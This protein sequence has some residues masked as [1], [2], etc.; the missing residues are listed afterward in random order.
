[1]NAAIQQPPILFNN[2][3]S[4]PIHRAIRRLRWFKSSFI[5]QVELISDET[6]IKYETDTEILA[7]CFISWLKLFEANKPDNEDAYQAFV[8]HA[9]GLML[10]R[11]IELKPLKT[12]SIPDPRDNNDPAQFWPEGYVYV[13]YCLNV[14]HLVLKRAFSGDSVFTNEFPDIQTWW[15]FKENVD[16]TPSYAIPFLDLF[17]GEVPDFSSLGKFEPEAQQNLATLT[18]FIKNQ[19]Q[20]AHVDIESTSQQVVDEL[21]YGLQL[22]T[23]YCQVIVTDRSGDQLFT[24]RVPYE[25]VDFEHFLA[26]HN[27][28]VEEWLKAGPELIQSN[29][30]APKKTVIVSIPIQSYTNSDNIKA[31]LVARTGKEVQ[32]IDTVSTAAI[33]QILRE[34]NAAASSFLFVSSDIPWAPKLVL[35]GQLMSGSCA[36]LDQYPAGKETNMIESLL[37]KTRVLIELVDLTDIVIAGSSGTEN[38][39]ND[40][41]NKIAG[42][43]PQLRVHIS[44]FVMTPEEFAR[45]CVYAATDVNW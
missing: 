31:K 20:L 3:G 32:V 10:R 19:A 24:E 17:A 22:D 38:I 34:P 41:L 5:T 45:I 36:V 15:S 11:L 14:R 42:E 27:T 23:H 2:L 37:T 9:S 39:K 8:G 26:Q 16:E 35:K 28:L 4:E 30:V 43:N 25:F 7:R 44:D 12:V 29:G 21:I 1:M 18:R 13:M 33:A 40:V 6:G